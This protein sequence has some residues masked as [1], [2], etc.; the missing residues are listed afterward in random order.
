VVP[1]HCCDD[2]EWVVSLSNNQKSKDAA[3]EDD[4]FL[5]KRTRKQLGNVYPKIAT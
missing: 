3:W 5:P 4:D 2:N 1:P